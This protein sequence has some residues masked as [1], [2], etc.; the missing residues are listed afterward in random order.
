MGARGYREADHWRFE[1]A[2]FVFHYPRWEGS[3][4]WAGKMPTRT[5]IV[6]RYAWARWGIWGGECGELGYV[7]GHI[8]AGSRNLS[9]VIGNRARSYYWA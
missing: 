9:V 6:V 8:D 3:R 5:D 1:D 2:D 7:S 4:W